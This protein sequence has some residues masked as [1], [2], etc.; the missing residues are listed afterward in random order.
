MIKCSLYAFFL[1]DDLGFESID[2][3]FATVNGTFEILPSQ[4]AMCKHHPHTCT[5]CRSL[6]HS[7]PLR[8]LVPLSMPRPAVPPVSI[9]LVTCRWS[10]AGTQDPKLGSNM[11]WCVSMS[12]WCALA[13]DPKSWANLKICLNLSLGYVVYFMS[14]V[15]TNYSN[16]WLFRLFFTMVSPFWMW[17]LFF[18]VDFSYFIRYDLC[19]EGL[20]VP[21]LVRNDRSCQT[22]NYSQLSLKSDPKFVE[23]I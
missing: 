10:K 20:P 19:S 12:F 23:F 4:L 22:F 16:C 17:L 14:A 8:P 15:C 21:R 18:L 6:S 11:F 5:A 3:N 13:V 9:P 1:Y 7:Y 2:L